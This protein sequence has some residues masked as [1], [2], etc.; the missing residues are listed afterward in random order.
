MAIGT[1]SLHE[2]M[3]CVMCSCVVVHYKPQAAM[4][5][6]R[7]LPGLGQHLIEV[8][9]TPLCLFIKGGLV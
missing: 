5:S 2:N 4:Q 6:L 3:L 9:G 7:V 1:V 8:W